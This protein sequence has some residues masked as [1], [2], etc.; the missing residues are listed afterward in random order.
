MPQRNERERKDQI[1][2]ERNIRID[3]NGDLYTLTS[4]QEWIRIS[5]DGSMLSYATTRETRLLD[6]ILELQK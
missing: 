4:N 1:N 6:L 2:M 5:Q 3:A